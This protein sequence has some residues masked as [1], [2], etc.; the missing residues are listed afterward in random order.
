MDPGSERDRPTGS[1]RSGCGLRSLLGRGDRHVALKE[2]LGAAYLVATEFEEVRH[3]LV[4]LDAAAEP[5]RIHVRQ[6]QYLV[7]VFA[8]L[9]DSEVPG[10]PGVRPALDELPKALLA[11]I[12]LAV[13]FERR[14]HERMPR[15]VLR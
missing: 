7:T 3:V 12:D 15:E 1:G 11:A 5:L 10:V 8:E 2:A 6:R 4:E 9:L 13:A 14:D